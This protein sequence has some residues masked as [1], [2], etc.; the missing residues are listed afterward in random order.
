MNFHSAE[1]PRLLQGFTLLE[2]LVVVAVLGL[3]AAFV[4]PRYFGQLTKSEVSIAH[5]QIKSLSDALD[6]FRIDEGRFPTT[7]EGLKALTEPPRNDS[8]WRGPYMRKGIPLD[9]WGRPY[10]YKS[11]GPK[12]SDFE[13]L[14]LG[15]D[16]KLGGEG[17]DAD[18]R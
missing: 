14:S 10:A 15:R 7:E 6:A 17:P 3:L 11:P 12:S 13:I 2:L 16:G 18:L 4:A 1:P 8:K 5:A 9:P